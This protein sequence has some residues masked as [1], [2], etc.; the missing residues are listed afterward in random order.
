MM[1]NNTDQINLLQECSPQ[2]RVN[3]NQ[4]NNIINFNQT[5]TFPEKVKYESTNRNN[6][7]FEVMKN[8]NNLYQNIYI[9]GNDN[10]FKEYD[11]NQNYLN[12]SPTIY[13]IGNL[14][15][16]DFKTAYNYTN[17]NYTNKESY[18]KDNFNQN[19][20]YRPLREDKKENLSFSKYVGSGQKQNNNLKI[21]TKLNIYKSE[22]QYPFNFIKNVP[23]NKAKY[24]SNNDTIESKK[25]INEEVFNIKYPT[26]NASKNKNKKNEIN[27]GEKYNTT[28]PNNIH[29][30]SKKKTI[31]RNRNNYNT[32][33]FG[34]NNE[35]NTD[36]A[37]NINRISTNKPSDYI[38]YY[39]NENNMINSYNNDYNYNNK[40]EGRPF[41]QRKGDINIVIP[42]NMNNYGYLKTIG[43]PINTHNNFEP[44]FNTCNT[45][46]RNE[47]NFNDNNN[48]AINVNNMNIDLNGPRHI[49]G[50][51]SFEIKGN[52]NNI[53]NNKEMNYDNFLDINKLIEYKKKLIT[54]FCHSI[55]DYIFMNVKNNFDYF[56]F[57]L[58]EY[59]RQK[60]YNSLLIRR[61]QINNIKKRSS[62]SNNY[63]LHNPENNIYSSLITNSSNR[64][65]HP[66]R[67]ND[68]SWEDSERK[69]TNDYRSK[70]YDSIA[71]N[72]PIFKEKYRIG[73]SHGRYEINNIDNYNNYYMNNTYYNNFEKI[74][75]LGN[76][77]KKVSSIEKNNNKIDNNNI[78]V[79]KKKFVNIKNKKFSSNTNSNKKINVNNYRNLNPNYNIFNSYDK[80]LLKEEKEEVNK[81]YNVDNINKNKRK[82]NNDFRIKNLKRLNLFSQEINNYKNYNINKDLENCLLKQE[83]DSILKSQ[84]SQKLIENKKV[85]NSKPIYK[86]KIKITQAKSKILK[87]KQ[88]QNNNINIIVEQNNKKDELKI[89]TFLVQINEQNSNLSN[90]ECNN[91]NNI[92]KIIE[93]NENN[94]EKNDDKKYNKNENDDSMNVNENNKNEIIKIENIKKENNKNNIVEN[95]NKNN[96]NKNN[97]IKE[98]KIDENLKN[99][100]NEDNIND[101][102]NNN[103]EVNR[104]KNKNNL[105]NEEEEDETDENIPREIIVKDVS[106]KDRRLN[107]FIKYIELLETNKI[108]NSFTKPIILFQTDSI[109]L[110]SSYQPK[111]KYYYGNTKEKSNKLELHKIL[112]SIIEEE[113]KSKLAGSENNSIISEE[114]NHNGNFSHFYIQSVKYITTFLQS[115]FDDKKKD[116]FFI[117]FKILKKIKNEAFLKGLMDQKKFETLTKLKNSND[118]ENE[119]SSSR[120]VLLYNDNYNYDD[121]INCFSS[122]SIVIEEKNEEKNKNKNSD[123]IKKNQNENII[124][125]IKENLDEDFVNKIK[126]KKFASATNFYSLIEDKEHLNLKKLNLSMNLNIIKKDNK[127]KNVSEEKSNKLNK[128][129][130]LINNNKKSNEDKKEDKEEDKDVDSIKGLKK[131]KEK[132][133]IINN[134]KNKNIFNA[135]R[136]FSDSIFD[137]KIYLVKYSLKNK[138]EAK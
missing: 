101:K 123:S 33:K 107:V 37:I 56:I 13:N 20:S 19:F 67:E 124:K 110:P 2:K 29:A 24:N 1:M 77:Y 83:N 61:L 60:Y 66:R 86:K 102:N 16:K 132:D 97:D 74:S 36:D 118:E 46:M 81:C 78:Y 70:K 113:E 21:G 111:K 119:N 134:E 87:K 115:I 112:S 38:T 12:N 8:V 122:K 130:E 15:T 127:L 71:G 131:E 116:K 98:E 92:N 117:F 57:N 75:G 109:Y 103:N 54:E 129:L 45:K 105:V 63:I 4:R 52:I 82:I 135:F 88:I 72:S 80:S 51:K 90:I 50:K 137:F 35:L 39:K 10:F 3:I 40:E 9:K 58:R 138:N 7:Q 100:K 99:N 85:L 95:D 79:P 11:L 27:D 69:I 53:N 14:S 48:Y 133:L 68:I 84:N 34:K 49:K 89:N 121:D 41:S 94:L 108:A 128:K 55:E 18:Y 17:E 32:I 44:S 30:S 65:F 47:T 106:T 31:K 76:M 25:H 28:F 96:I 73:K 136:D 59:C 22:I 6:I 114:D 5:Q 62:S 64:N 43:N 125:N 91:Q 93:N 42:N 104:I 26:K 120:E 126:N 23:R